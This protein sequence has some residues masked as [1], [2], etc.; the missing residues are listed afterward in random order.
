MCAR[1]QQSPGRSIPFHSI[2]FRYVPFHSIPFHSIPFHSLSIIIEGNQGGTKGRWTSD[3]DNMLKHSVQ[4][5]GGNDW[6]V[7]AALV[8]GRTKSQCHKRWQNAYNHSI[9]R[10][11]D[12]RVNGEKTKTS[13]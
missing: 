10:R 1:Q 8:P 7:I 11:M 9:D 5:H 6:V 2:P 4:M 12:V 13:A 3:E